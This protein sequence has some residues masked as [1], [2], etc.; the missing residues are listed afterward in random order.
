MTESTEKQTAVERAS[1]LSDEL[2]ESVDLDGE[3]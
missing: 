3:H 2:L 1:D